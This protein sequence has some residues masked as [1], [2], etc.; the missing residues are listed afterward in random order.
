MYGKVLTPV[1]VRGIA[2]RTCRCV[3]ST[4]AG[5]MKQQIPRKKGK[6]SHLWLLRQFSDPYVEKAKMSNYRCRSAF[7]LREIDDRFRIL[8]PGQ[9]VIDC[10]AAPGSW[11]Q[12]AVERVNALGTE[13]KQ[14]VGHVI[15]VDCLPIYPVNGAIILGGHDFTEQTTQKKLREHLNNFGPADVILSDMAPNATGVRVL[16]QENILVLAYAA[17]K[18]ALTVSKPGSAILL[19]KIWDGGGVPSLCTDLNR[20]YESVKVVKPA[21]SRTDS[22]EKFILARGFKKSV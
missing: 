18:F 5:N 11:T 7:K 19:V 13:E 6:S 12:V 9:C 4:T 8:S 14:P 20:Y 16:D 21:A 2:S 17:F 22:A 15:A 1:H 3:F 10:G